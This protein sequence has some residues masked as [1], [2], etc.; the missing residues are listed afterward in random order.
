MQ[1][2]AD[3]GSDQTVAQR[4]TGAQ[5]SGSVN[6]CGRGHLDAAGEFRWL[7]LTEGVAMV[8][9]VVNFSM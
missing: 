5:N 3:T 8:S 6:Y 7:R 1:P 9:A 4:T 2:V